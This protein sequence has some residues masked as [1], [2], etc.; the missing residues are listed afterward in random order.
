M[1]PL[2]SGN[3]A[4]AFSATSAT[5]SR[6]ALRA[7]FSGKLPLKASSQDTS[8]LDTELA[9]MKKAPLAFEGLLLGRVTCCLPAVGHAPVS[10]LP[11]WAI[12]PGWL[13]TC[14]S[15]TLHPYG[16]LGIYGWLCGASVT[17]YRPCGSV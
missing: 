11:A 5:A 1:R 2:A 12:S 10:F 7:G 17:W 8:T 16:V 13:P 14:L 15:R 3:A 6:Q 9:T 4:L